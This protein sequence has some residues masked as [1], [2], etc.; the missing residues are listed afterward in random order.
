MWQSRNST[1]RGSSA[2]L[3]Y[4]LAAVALVVVALVAPLADPRPI[5]TMDQPRA[6]SAFLLGV[7]ADPPLG[8]AL[9]IPDIASQPLAGLA[10]LAG[11]PIDPP[12]SGACYEPARPCGPP[13]VAPGDHL[14]APT[15]LAL[16]IVWP[17]VAWA[18]GVSAP[19]APVWTA[20]PT[21]PPR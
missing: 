18:S 7:T 21:G 14:V 3:L 10:P 12:V 11:Q 2:R 15:M 8:A 16:G 17:S 20:V 4:V 13:A 19:P 6:S 1:L 9:V 5:D